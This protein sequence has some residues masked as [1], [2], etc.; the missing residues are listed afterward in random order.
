MGTTRVDAYRKAGPVTFPGGYTVV[1]VMDDG[2]LMCH[3]CVVASDEVHDHDGGC[4]DGWG[5][6]SGDI[7]WEGPSHYC[8]E[9]GVELPTEYGDPGEPDLETPVERDGWPGGAVV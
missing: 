2:E 6:V 8:A 9:C 1:A 7:L 3:A 4:G 5:F